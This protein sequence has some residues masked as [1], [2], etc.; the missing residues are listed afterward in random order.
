VRLKPGAASRECLPETTQ[1]H[2]NTAEI[3]LANNIHSRQSANPQGICAAAEKFNKFL[4]AGVWGCFEIV[5]QTFVCASR[6]L[7]SGRSIISNFLYC[8]L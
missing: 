3:P 1:G 8:D 2:V 4:D 7:P 6:R 5:A